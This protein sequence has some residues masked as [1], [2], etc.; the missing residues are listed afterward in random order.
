MPEP[1]NWNVIVIGS[2]NLAILSPDGIRRRLFELPDQSA[3][4]LE[5]AVDRPGFF[6]VGHGGILVSPTPVGLEVAMRVPN[7]ESLARACALCQRALR[8]LP[9]T[10]VSAAGINIRYRFPEMPD[11]LFDLMHA[12]M[13]ETLADAEFRVTA[14]VVKKTLALAPG[15]VNVQMNYEGVVGAL[16]FNFHRDSTT[17]NDL[18]DWLGRVEEFRGLADRLLEVLGVENVRREINA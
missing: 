17:L 18:Y 9:E 5:M 11:N 16:D 10:P 7:A 6:R 12:P 4:E 8:A 15:V 2:W 1:F 13:D 14:T 3:I